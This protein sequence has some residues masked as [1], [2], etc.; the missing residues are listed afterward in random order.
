MYVGMVVPRSMHTR[1][2]GIT[3]DKVHQSLHIISREPSVLKIMSTHATSILYQQ[4]S[5][6]CIALQNSTIVYSGQF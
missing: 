5:M 3:L 1:G 2:A 6:W 4:L